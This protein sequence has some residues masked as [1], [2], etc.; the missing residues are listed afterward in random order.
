MSH[1]KWRE[2]KQQPGMLPGPAVPGC[3]SVSFHILWAILSTST[4]QLANSYCSNSRQA[5]VLL[6]DLHRR[7]LHHH[8]QPQLSRALPQQRPL[9][10]HDPLLAPRHLLLPPQLRLLR[11]RALRRLHQGLPLRRRRT[12]LR[13]PDRQHVIQG[14][15]TRS[16]KEQYLACKCSHEMLMEGK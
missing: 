7:P 11:R 15:R 4:V 3:C 10:L 2:T 13:H 6:E 8:L 14:W 12:H 16:E 9:L 1:R 5:D